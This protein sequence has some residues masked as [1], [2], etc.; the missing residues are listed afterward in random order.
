MGRDVDWWS[1]GGVRLRSCRISFDMDDRMVRGKERKRAQNGR[2]SVSL[3]IN[4]LPAD[5]NAPVVRRTK[6]A[7]VRKGQTWNKRDAQGVNA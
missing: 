6:E 4:I 5:M 2:E 7:G 1:L 3:S